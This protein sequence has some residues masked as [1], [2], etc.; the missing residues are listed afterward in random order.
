M[1]GVVCAGCFALAAAVLLVYTLREAVLLGADEYESKVQAYFGQNLLAKSLNKLAYKNNPSFLS[2]I[3]ESKLPFRYHE[4]FKK[5]DL[6]ERQE[7]YREICEKIWSVNRF[8]RILED[9]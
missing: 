3:R 7:L 8:E 6:D 1:P 5:E 2:F 9:E 4:K